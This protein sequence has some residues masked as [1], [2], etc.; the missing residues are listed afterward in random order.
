M[1]LYINHQANIFEIEEKETKTGKVYVTCNVVFYSKSKDKKGE[2]T[3]DDKPFTVKGVAFG[4]TAETLSTRQDE[5]NIFVT[6]LGKLVD[7]VYEKEG[8]KVYTK[9]FEIFTATEAIAH[10]ELEAEATEADF[11]EAEI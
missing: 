3:V 9:R 8:K 10:K 5:K 1:A 7:T 4:K 2:Y 11:A 6:V